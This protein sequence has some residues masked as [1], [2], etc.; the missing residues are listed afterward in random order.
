MI[1]RVI[2]GPELLH[3]S[4]LGAPVSLGLMPWCGPDVSR[5]DA[6]SVTHPR[7][8]RVTRMPGMPTT[9]SSTW[10]YVSPQLPAACDQRLSSLGVSC[11]SP[12]SCS[13]E[14]PLVLQKVIPIAGWIENLKEGH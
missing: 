3:V 2:P 11:A 5:S 10:H 6:L 8:Q 9:Q 4:L 13:L 12:P 7:P 1:S 14:G